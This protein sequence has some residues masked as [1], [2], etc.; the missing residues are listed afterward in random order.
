LRQAIK[1]IATLKSAGADITPIM[2]PIVYNTDTRFGKCADFISEIETLSGKKILHT[3]ADAEP[4]GPRKLLD[5]LVVAPC[6]G[7]TLGKLANGITDTSVTMA[8]K[9]HLRNERPVVL[10]VAT[11]DALGASAKNIGLLFNSRHIYFVPLSQDDPCGKPN[12]LIA[13]FK[14]IPETVTAAL[15]GNQIQPVLF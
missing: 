4:I 9:A 3:V 14:K 2:S 11:N 10:A 7:N 15:L 6:T 8:I 5:V 12:S 1:E 13:D